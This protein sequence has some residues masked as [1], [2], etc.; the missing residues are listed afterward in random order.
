MNALYTSLPCSPHLVAIQTLSHV[1]SPHLRCA[2]SIIAD[3]ASWRCKEFP[4]ASAVKEDLDLLGPRSHLRC[5][6][7]IDRTAARIKN[8]TRE[9]RSLIS[10]MCSGGT[11]SAWTPRHSGWHRQTRLTVLATPDCT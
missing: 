9:F 2:R 5:D 7:R 4:Y 10:Q 1:E 8:K 11:C 6:I 3:A